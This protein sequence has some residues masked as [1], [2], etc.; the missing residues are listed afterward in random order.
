M[1][2]FSWAIVTVCIWGVVPIIEKHALTNTAPLVGVFFRSMGVVIGLIF[3]GLFAIRPGDL[4]SVDIKTVLLLMLAGVLASLVAQITFYN[5]LKLGEVSR[6]TPL[7]G[8]YYLIT[9]VL[10]VFLLGESITVPKV[11]G[12]L[13]IAGG[14]WLLR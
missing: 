13:L 9:F 12:V 11:C 1:T 8:T 6:I 10:G 2:A 5:A 14:A 4:K 3:F 7:C